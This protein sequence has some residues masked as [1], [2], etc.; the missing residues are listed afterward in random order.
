[1]TEH[2]NHRHAQHFLVALVLIFLGLT[3]LLLSGF[4]TPLALGIILAILGYG[5]HQK[6]LDKFKGK[7]NLAALIT[8]LA[9]MTVIILPT[10]LFLGVLFNEAVELFITAQNKIDIAEFFKL[11]FVENLT[12]KLNFNVENL[13]YEQFVPTIKSLGGYISTQ[14]GN[15]FSNVLNL[16]LGFF[17][18]LVTAF[19]IM[20]DGKAFGNFLIKA[21]PLKIDDELR[22]YNVFRQVTGAVFYGNFVSAMAQGF[23]GGLGFWFFGLGSPVLWGTI[24]GLLSLIP[25]LGPFIIF[26]PA[27]IYFVIAGKWGLLIGFLIYN[28]VIVSSIDNIIKPK[29]IGDKISMHPL[30]ILVAILG[31]L[32]LFGILGIIYGPLIVSIFIALIHIYSEHSK[33]P[34]NVI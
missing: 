7:K 3:I 6:I 20:R 32:K 30:L 23:L 15:I 11:P 19:Y 24:M 29:L 17:I 25:V 14:I 27:S 21:S 22:L 34:S 2:N 16:V 28:L 33:E 10:V 1:M 26:I 8:L 12:Q 18:M 5:W 4:F 9:I 13:A 31:G